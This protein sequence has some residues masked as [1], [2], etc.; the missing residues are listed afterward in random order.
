MKKMIRQGIALIVAFTFMTA[1]MGVQA[2]TQKSEDERLNLENVIAFAEQ[3]TSRD[4]YQDPNIQDGRV[5]WKMFTDARMRAKE[6]ISLPQTTQEQL[7]IEKTALLTAIENNGQ[8]YNRGKAPLSFS[9]ENKAEQSNV[10]DNADGTPTTKETA[11]QEN[12]TTQPVEQFVSIDV[13]GFTQ[14][15]ENEEIYVADNKITSISGTVTGVDSITGISISFTVGKYQYFTGDV[16]TNP[17]WVLSNP[18]IMTG[19]NKIK[20]TVNGNESLSKTITLVNQNEGNAAG[21]VLD[22][23]DTD[24]D[25]LLNY[26]EDIYGTS[27]TVADTDGDGLTDFQEVTITSTDPLKVDTDGNGVSDANEDLDGDNLSNAA[28]VKLGSNPFYE[29]SDFDGLNDDKEVEL[30][31][32]VNDADTDKDGLNDGD[33]ITYNM[34]PKNPDT[35][36]DGVSD[37]NRTFKITKTSDEAKENDAAVPSVELNVTGTQAG[38]LNVSKVPETDKFLNSQI[39]GYIGNAYDFTIDGEFTSATI[40]FEFDQSLNAREEFEP[41]IFHFNEETQLLEELQNQTVEGNKVSAQTTHFS[42][43]ILLNRILYYRVWNATA[44]FTNPDIKDGYDVVFAIDAT[45]VSRA[46]LS[47]S[48]YNTIDTYIDGMGENDRIAAVGFN[49]YE[50]PV[51]EFTNDKAKAKSAIRTIQGGYLKNPTW[52]MLSVMQMFYGGGSPGNKLKNIVWI[53]DG[54]GSM[55]ENY[56]TQ[57]AQYDIKVHTIGVGNVTDTYLSRLADHS[58]GKY[59]PAGNVSD[60]GIVFST[61]AEERYRYM[62]SDGDGLSDYYKDLLSKG[63]IILGNGIPVSGILKDALDSDGDGIPDGQELTISQNGDKAY[64]HITSDPTSN[65]SDGDGIP[66]NEDTRPFMWDVSNRDLAMFSVL[67]YENMSPGQMVDTYPGALDSFGGIAHQNELKG[68]K[69]LNTA[70]KFAEQH[71]GFYGAVF[72]KD[73]NMVFAY[74]GSEPSLIMDFIQ[75]FI[76]ADGV[77][78]GTGNNIQTPF[79]KSLVLN[80]LS[81]Y[82]PT[83]RKIYATGHSLGGYLAM[84]STSELIRL[85]KAGEL[86]KNV[87]FNAPGLNNSIH[88]FNSDRDDIKRL[89]PHQDKIENWRVKGDVISLVNKHVGSVPVVE[90]GQLAKDKYFDIIYGPHMMLSFFENS[91]FTRQVKL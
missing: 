32:D 63:Q 18:I 65:D 20:V 52:A 12:Q 57:P 71:V 1:I 55:Q 5:Q 72:V 51:L 61:I 28:E 80:S 7:E 58:G 8:K 39:P 21:L 40:T 6:I 22:E 41:A 67:A 74:R 31:T 35:L 77:G 64:A 45:A 82:A 15:L 44:A 54:T 84:H 11:R 34:N 36:G 38:T 42:T 62:D 70:T 48:L 25:G 30:K 4:E 50:Y 60:L 3:M 13:S 9:S 83:G 26:M 81:E 33:E 46:G 66:D 27:K 78:I 88:I 59:Y 86:V 49:S 2:A 17:N 16:G 56:L 14:L 73:D 68:W 37:G 47:Q 10:G 75:D 29:D 76:V 24:G 79:A 89:Q 23:N 87:N 53:T 43:F 19:T 90:Y 85:N 69:V 91:R